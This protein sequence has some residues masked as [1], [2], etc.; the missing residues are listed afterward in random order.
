MCSSD[1]DESEEEIKSSCKKRRAVVD[2]SSD[3]DAELNTAINSGK[4]TRNKGK[5]YHTLGKRRRVSDD[6]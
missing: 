5:F 4:T 3:S 6:I 1:D 2:D